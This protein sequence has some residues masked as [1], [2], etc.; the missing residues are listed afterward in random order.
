VPNA[1]RGMAGD[2]ASY[3]P[4]NLTLTYTG[5]K[6]WTLYAGIDNLF[7]RKPPFDPVWMALPTGDDTSLYS[8]V[9]RFAQV[10]TT[11]KF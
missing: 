4:F 2:V 1:Y 3:G 6:H 11:Y 7:N 8:D 5:F 9:G 10:G